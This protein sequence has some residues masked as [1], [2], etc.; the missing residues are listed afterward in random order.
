MRKSVL[1][2]IFI[3]LVCQMAVAQVGKMAAVTNKVNNGYDFWLYAPQSYYDNPTAKQPVIIYLHGAKLCGRGLRSFHKYLTLD[4]IAKGRN[5]DAMVIAPQNHGGGWKPERLNNVLQ[6][7]IDN[8]PVDTNRVYVLGMSLGGYGAMDFVGTYPEKIAAAMALC[9]GCTLSDVQGLGKLPFWIFHGTADRA[10]T[11]GQS[12]KVVSAL[13][14]AGND[15]LLRY[16][17]LPGANHGQPA[18]IYYLEETYQWLF[19]HNKSDVPQKVDRDII[20]NLNVMSKAYKGLNSKGTIPKVNSI[21]ASKV[22]ENQDID[23]NIATDDV[24]E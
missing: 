13:Q 3:V 10:V 19:K 20:I 11:I 17:W 6:W 8:Y 23:D 7:V 9:G 12:K 5:I 22:D 24:E 15:K 1:S 14:Q 2:L 18:R 21:K 4:A 16:E